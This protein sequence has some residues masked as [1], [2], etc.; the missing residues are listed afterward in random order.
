MRASLLVTA[1]ALVAGGCTK[2]RPVLGT[3]AYQH[4]WKTTIASLL[5]TR[6]GEC[7][8]TAGGYSVAT[9]QSTIG[10]GGPRL[11]LAG[12]PASILL[13]LLDPQTA[14]APHAGFDDVH[15]A[16][17]IW[18]L[19]D[20]LAYEPS[21]VH[22]AGIQ[23]PAS[24][25]FHKQLVID[26]GYDLGLCQKCHGGDFS[27]G[28]SGVSCNG[29]H[30]ET[31]AGCTTCHGQP[32]SSGAH[33]M[34]TS[35]NSLRR[36]LDCSECHLKPTAWNDPGHIR[37]QNGA[38]LPG[39]AQVVFGPLASTP[40]DERKAAPQWDGVRCT[41]VYC[42]GAAFSDSFATLVEP[43]WT[44]GADAA[45]CGTC[46]GVPPA[47]H[48]G[49]SCQT[50]H[51][52]TIDASGKII[53]PDRHIDGKITLGI[54]GNGTCTSC[55]PN[56]GGAHA[57]HTGALHKIT[58]PIAC[59]EC[60]IVPTTVTQP[61]HL[62]TDG[63]ATVFPPG[64]VGPR[65]SAFSAMPSFDHDAGRCSEVACHGGGTKL[66]TDMASSIVRMPAW[67]SGTVASC[68]TC[69]GVPPKDGIHDAAWGLTTCASC[70]P[71]T[72][73]ASGQI[74]VSGGMS[75]HINGMVDVQ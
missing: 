16:L 8:G 74:L 46:H 25:G 48:F 4:T 39:P 53:G 26:R 35:D 75:T 28:T 71:K 5:A 17:R 67:N 1:L 52:A 34:H 57:A 11:A 31:P 70:H 21:D 38:L 60:H 59:T 27:G 12:D 51:A 61:G 22:V 47:N 55:H 66:A 44:G 50:C 23:D 29:C 9:Y 6:C 72:I 20:S 41:N 54:D 3:R 68:G 43:A 73:D 49:G 69:H 7:H 32:P 64:G 37:D 30:K 2:A 18:I 45:A 24:P 19:D 14:T 13:Q 40:T 65:A 56:P 15:A 33:L 63:L 62:S 42:H 58:T 36:G 10:V